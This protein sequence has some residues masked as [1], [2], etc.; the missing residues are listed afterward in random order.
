MVRTTRTP[1]LDIPN[2]RDMVKLIPVHHSPADWNF[3]SGVGFAIDAERFVSPPSAL[4]RPTGSGQGSTG[5]LTLKESTSGNLKDGRLTTYRL[6]EHNTYGHFWLFMRAQTQ[7]T[8]E[9]PPNCYFFYNLHSTLE[10]W[11]RVWGANSGLTA[12][13]F[14]PPQSINTWYR[15]RYTWY[16]WLDAS[17]NPVLRFQA[18]RQ[19]AGIWKLW[20][21]YDEPN[22][23]WQ[24]SAINLIGMQL[25]GYTAITQFWIDDTEIFTRCPG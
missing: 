3:Q 16:T 8:N 19:E 7:P 21:Q 15:W 2:Q 17:L 9:L 18:E 4:R 22:P 1:N 5:L 10:L 24:D 11:R 13:A 20:L 14:D 25:G 12:I 23:R 6:H